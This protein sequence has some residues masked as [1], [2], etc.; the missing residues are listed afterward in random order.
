MPVGRERAGGGHLGAAAGGEG[1]GVDRGQ[2]AG[3]GGGGQLADAVP[4]HDALAGVV[5]AELAG[6]EHAERDD[7]RLGDRG[8]LDLVGVG[9]GAEPV[10]VQ[11]GPLNP[12]TCSVAP[13]SSSQGRSMPGVCDPCPGAKIAITTPTVS[14]RRPGRR[15]GRVQGCWHVCGGYLQ[16]DPSEGHTPAVFMI[17]TVSRCGQPSAD[18][19]SIRGCCRAGSAPSPGRR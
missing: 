2:R 19:R 12:A 3:D 7:Q 1:H 4:G 17:G 10:E 16:T 5:E 9:G 6:G 13:G 8:V 11:P 14:R 15:R 18:V